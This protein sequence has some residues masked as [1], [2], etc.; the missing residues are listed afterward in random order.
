MSNKLQPNGMFHT[1]SGSSELYAW[2][3][4]HPADE[5]IHLYTAAM[6]AWNLACRIVNDDDEDEEC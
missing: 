4:A 3:E 1:P 6:M 5:R 2:I